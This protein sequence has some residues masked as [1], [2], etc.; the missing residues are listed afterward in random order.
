MTGAY[1]RVKRD[2]KWEN[3]EVEHLT[4][5]EI[6]EMFNSKDKDEIM[7]WFKLVCKTLSHVEN[8]YFEPK[9]KE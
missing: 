7:R 5:E 1:L 3:I 6:D 9:D 8:E 4:E 2:S